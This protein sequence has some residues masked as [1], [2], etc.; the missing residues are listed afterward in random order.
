MFGVAAARGAVRG[1]GVGRRGVNLGD[2][3]GGPVRP[4]PA[5]LVNTAYRA[6]FNT[7]Q[8]PVRWSAHADYR[9]PFTLDAGF[10]ALVDQA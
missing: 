5:G 4:V 8:L 9:P 3:L 6:G 2:A 10:A 1:G 7:V